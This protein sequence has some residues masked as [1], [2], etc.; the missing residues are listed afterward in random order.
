MDIN[1]LPLHTDHALLHRAQDLIGVAQVRQ[2]WIFMLDDEDRQ[3]TTLPVIELPVHLGE[4][5]I[6]QLA[7]VVHA[8]KEHTGV[9]A[10]ALVWELPQASA[11]EGWVPP[12]MFAAA[13]RR[14]RLELR[15]QL[16]ATN[17]GVATWI[18]PVAT[19]GA[20]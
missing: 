19:P 8:I 2:I 4:L 20:A 6:D 16:V 18:A 11:Q 7:D 5:E 17:E 12:S 3:L 13:A 1:P 10:L 14:L 9:P 15:G